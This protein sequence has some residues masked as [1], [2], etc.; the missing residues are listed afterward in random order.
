MKFEREIRELYTSAFPPLER[1]HFWV[2]KNIQKRKKGKFYPIVQL[3]HFIGFFFTIE[4]ETCVYLFF[5]AL[6]PSLRNQGLGGKALDHM[7]A[8]FKHKKVFLLTEL[9]EEKNSLPYRRKNFYLRH[10]FKET[11]CYFKENYVW[12]EM[13]CQSDDFSRKEYHQLMKEA[14]SPLEY[15][16]FFNPQDSKREF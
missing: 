11:H 3:N 5:F 1:I 8:R 14:F 4:N 12:Y 15:R 9:V 2:L 16:F 6:D 10:G 7:V 13:L